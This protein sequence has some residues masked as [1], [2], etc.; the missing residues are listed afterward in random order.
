MTAPL[1]LPASTRQRRRHLGVFLAAF[2]VVLAGVA[3]YT[4]AQPK[5]YRSTATLQL[6]P[7]TDPGPARA[8]E[9]LSGS[10]LIRKVA[11][12]LSGEELRQ[13]T[14]PYESGSDPL[15]PPEVLTENRGILP[16]PA[17][18]RILIQY[19]HPDPAFAA[20]VANL[21][22]EEAAALLDPPSDPTRARVLERAQPAAP[23]DYVSPSLPLHFGLGL[24]LAA[25]AGLAAM[26]VSAGFTLIA[27][28]DRA[29]PAAP[30]EVD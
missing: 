18:A 22:A 28:A 27:R 3:A 19:H 13:L 25:A 30:T 10:A 11:D 12:R 6:A 15:T 9:A 16:Q 4:L 1:L 23:S 24:L 8:A 26:L 7:G 21:F 29:D 17:A 20:M 2:L 5:I 14:A